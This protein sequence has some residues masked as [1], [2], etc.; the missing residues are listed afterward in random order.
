[1]YL[2]HFRLKKKKKTEAYDLEE[3]IVQQP[4]NTNN[5]T[6]ISGCTA[7]SDQGAT[8]WLDV[9]GTDLLRIFSADLHTE[10]P[11]QMDPP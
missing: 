9:P 6:S 4:G 10:N 5:I 1:M 11:Q 8:F 2:L 7:F 3:V